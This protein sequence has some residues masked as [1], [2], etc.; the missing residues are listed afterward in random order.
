MVHLDLRPANI[1]ITQNTQNYAIKENVN[2][3]E[4]KTVSDLIFEDAYVLRLGDLG[5]AC[6][7]NETN[8]IEG[9][10]RYGW[11]FRLFDAI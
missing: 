1:F 10:S 3:V 8:W 2:S 4:E 5:H 6:M 9:E 7:Y 11:L